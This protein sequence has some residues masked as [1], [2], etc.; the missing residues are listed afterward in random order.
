MDS[1]VKQR[2]FQPLLLL[3]AQANDKQLASYLQYL[4]T[5]N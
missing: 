4:K 1:I 2:F 5:V 3:L